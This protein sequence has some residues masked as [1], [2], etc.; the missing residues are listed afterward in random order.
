MAAGPLAH[1]KEPSGSTSCRWQT[2]GWAALGRPLHPPHSL[3][4]QGPPTYPLAVILTGRLLRVFWGHR[5]Q[6]SLSIHVTDQAAAVW[7]ACGTLRWQGGRAL[8]TWP[9]GPS[10]W[11]HPLHGAWCPAVMAFSPP[12]GMTH[13]KPV[14]MFSLERPILKLDSFIPASKALS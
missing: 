9:L 13:A 14:K 3:F 2:R 12:P 7:Q 1:A 8:W 5:S 11:C 4:P 6:D 10:L